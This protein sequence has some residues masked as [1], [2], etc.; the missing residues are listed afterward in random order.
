MS[1]RI[2]ND[3]LTFSLGNLSYINASY[4]EQ[5]GAPLAPPKRSVFDRLREWWQRRQ[6]VAGLAHMTDRELADIGLSR[7]DLSRVFDPEFAA[8]HSHNPD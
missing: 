8:E 2:T 4:D 6:V 1:A 3:V 5:P 7:T